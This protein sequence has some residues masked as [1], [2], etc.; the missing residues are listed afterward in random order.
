MI[1]FLTGYQ[2]R[3]ALRV[4]AENMM[5]GDISKRRLM[6]KIKKEL[7][8][9][10]NGER[11]PGQVICLTGKDQIFSIMI[12]AGPVKS[13]EAGELEETYI[14]SIHKASK[15]PQIEFKI[16]SLQIP[17]VNITIG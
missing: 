10:T 13:V 12:N 14:L 1:S 15:E 11:D 16:D 3:K 5:P 6:E 7:N 4:S 8:F 17:K 2:I 9:L